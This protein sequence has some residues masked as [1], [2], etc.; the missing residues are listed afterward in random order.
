MSI[1]SDV[2]LKI[3][4]KLWEG[5]VVVDGAKKIV[6]WNEAAEKI[7]GLTKNEVLEKPCDGSLFE[8]ADMQGALLCGT[9]HAL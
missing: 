8:H 1:T 5:V 2:L 9:K 3:L 7:T 6:Y 4:D